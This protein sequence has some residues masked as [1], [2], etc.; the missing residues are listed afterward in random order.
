[1]VCTHP[2]S[3][4]Q[5]MTMSATP[6]YLLAGGIVLILA[7]YFFASLRR[8]GAGHFFIDPRMSDEE[9]ERL[10]DEDRGN[11][12]ANFLMLVGF[13]AVSLSVALRLARF[14]V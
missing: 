12:V 7:G 6:W 11:P 4:Q 1:M 14:F 2:S 13:M 8:P 5:G 9:I 3:K 10:L